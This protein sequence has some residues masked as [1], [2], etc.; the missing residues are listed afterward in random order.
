MNIKYF[1]IY[2]AVL[3]LL[4]YINGLILLLNN[5]NRKYLLLYNQIEMLLVFIFL[6]T[7][8]LLKEV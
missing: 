7:L 8:W 2:S 4:Q 5:H 3:S 1:I 6:V